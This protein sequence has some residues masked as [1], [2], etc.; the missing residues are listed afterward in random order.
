MQKKCFS[1]FMNVGGHCHI[2]MTGNSD[3]FL[4]SS[5][6]VFTKLSG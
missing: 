4:M 1:I 3:F 5:G 6:S 2:I